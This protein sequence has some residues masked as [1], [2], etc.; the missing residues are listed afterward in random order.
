M[1]RKGQE[2]P[3]EIGAFFYHL[4]NGDIIES[5]PELPPTGIVSL[6]CLRNG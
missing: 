6:G 2:S 5:L 3:G 1:K 4:D